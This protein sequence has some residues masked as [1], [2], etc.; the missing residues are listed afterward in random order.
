MLLL[1]L[2]FFRCKEHDATRCKELILILFLFLSQSI[3]DE[4]EMIEKN[5]PLDSY[6]TPTLN[7]RIALFAISFETIK[8]LDQSISI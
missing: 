8:T 5:H 3:L 4:T 7:N 1:F 6:H 2:P